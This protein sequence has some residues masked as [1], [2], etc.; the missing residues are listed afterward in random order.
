LTDVADKAARRTGFVQRQS[1]LTGAK[2][3]QTLVFGWLANPQATLEELSQTA[4]VVGV[5]I[6]AQGLEQRFS[7]A[8]AACLHHV[9]AETIKQ[10]VVSNPVGVPILR[11]F[12]GVYIQD[13][14]S[15]SLPARL[16]EVWQGCG[17]KAG[18]GLAALKLQVRLDMVTGRLD[19]PFLQAG[20]AQDRQAPLQHA[21][22]PAG[23]LRIADLGYW[24]LAV[25]AD[26]DRAGVYWL[27][28]LQAQTVVY[29]IHGQRWEVNDLLPAQGSSKVDIAVQLGV[30]QRLSARLLAVRVPQPVADLRRMRLKAQARHQGQAVSQTRLKWADWDIFVTNVPLE[31]LTL[32][33]AL[34]LMHIRWQIELIFK[35]WKSHSHLDAWRST[36]PWRILC[37]VY[38]K[39]IAVVMQHWLF[40]VGCWQ[41][42]NRSL[43]KAA[44]T[45]QK[46]AWHVAASLGGQDQLQAALSVVE[47]CLAVGCRINKRKTVPHTY[48]R[49]LALTDGG[50]G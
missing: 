23:A 31:W 5:E 44:Q 10:V 26:L 11:R 29:D 16:A 14:S 7:R 50:L 25:L 21:A 18:Q 33:E 41:Y 34:V 30:S 28:R 4:A 38:A 22:L 46:H 19:G 27:S 45:V 8:A 3:C 15:L 9:L 13:S 1:K 42:P 43:F 40:L 39:L 32:D 36:K 35:L 2:F 47:R 24:S 20:R 6:S 37:E 48:Q 49:L 12:T 17:G